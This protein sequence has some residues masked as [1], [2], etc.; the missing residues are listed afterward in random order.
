MKAGARRGIKMGKSN[1]SANR[2]VPARTRLDH[3]LS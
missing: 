2:E 3:E 1:K